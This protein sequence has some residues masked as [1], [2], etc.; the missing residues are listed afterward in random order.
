M[1]T[2]EALGEERDVPDECVTRFACCGSQKL[3]KSLFVLSVHAIHAV[4]K[5]AYLFVSCR[6]VRLWWLGS[7]DL[8]AS[9][10]K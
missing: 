9:E 5:M 1:F 2:D 7:E 3:P 4:G 8:K 10:L 6:V